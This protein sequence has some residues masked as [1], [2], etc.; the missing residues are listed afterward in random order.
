MFWSK[1]IFAVKVVLN[2]MSYPHTTTKLLL[3]QYWKTIALG[4]ELELGLWW[5][6]L[7]LQ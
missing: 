1:N 4:E 7:A 3:I 6:G 5:L 2:P